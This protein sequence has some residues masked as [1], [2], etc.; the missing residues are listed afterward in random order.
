[1]KNDLA[2]F[3]T[4]SGHASILLENGRLEQSLAQRT[5]LK[6]ELRHQAYHD[7]LTGLPTRLLFTDRVADAPGRGRLEGARTPALFLDLA[8]FKMV[9]DSWGHAIGDELLVRV[10]ERIRCNVAEADTAARLGG[11]EF[12]VL[13]ERT[14]AQGAE[15]TAERLTAALELPFYLS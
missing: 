9:N 11:D 3:E 1:S 5:A 15:E 10:A 12:A 4:F 13:L 8:R 6:E 7:V 2:L 14:N